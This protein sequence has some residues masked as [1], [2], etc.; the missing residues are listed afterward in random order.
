MGLVVKLNMSG[1]GIGKKNYILGFLKKKKKKTFT[2]ISYIGSIISSDLPFQCCVFFRYWCVVSMTS[3]GYGDF[4]PI[5]LPG[6]I[7][8]TVTLFIG[9]LFIALPVIILGNEFQS[10]YGKNMAYVE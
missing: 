2:K 7:V 5:E 1:Y 3:V 10:A 8:A 6:K 9:V 4:Y